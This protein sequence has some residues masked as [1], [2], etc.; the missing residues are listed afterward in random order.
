M[1]IRT[2]QPGDDIAQVSVYNEAAAT[3]PRFKPAT[4]DEVRRRV[5]AA[6]FDPAA[7]FYAV[8]DGQVAG[9]C[10]AQ[11]SGRI[12]YPWCRKGKEQWA[13]PL[14]ERVLQTMKERGRKSAWAAYRTDWPSVQEFFTAKGFVVAREVHNF[15]IDLVEMPTPAARATTNITPLTPDDLPFLKEKAPDLLRASTADLERSLFRNSWF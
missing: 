14:L 11:A 15:V 4:I 10:T 5:R 1:T 7:R 6:D 12:S 13:E 9:Y 8:E 3:L 2:F